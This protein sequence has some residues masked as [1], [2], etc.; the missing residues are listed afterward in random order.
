MNMYLDKVYLAAKFEEYEQARWLMTQL[1]ERGFTITYDWTPHALTFPPESEHWKQAVLDV[2]GVV[3]CDY[4]I[5]LHHPKSKGA[6]VELGVALALHKNII[7]IGCKDHGDPV[8]YWHPDIQHVTDL[9]ALWPLLPRLTHV[10]DPLPV[11]VPVHKLE[12]K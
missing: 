3:D 6:L 1:R 12:G 8:F 5:Q 11:H 10:P 2:A 4:F 7:V 9:D